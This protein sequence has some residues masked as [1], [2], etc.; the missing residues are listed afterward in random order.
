MVYFEYL[1]CFCFY[2]LCC[3]ILQMAV[4]MS[5]S[6]SIIFSLLMAYAEYRQ[7]AYLDLPGLSTVWATTKKKL[8][9][10]ASR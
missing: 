9:A 1:C 5:L 2:A 10:P 8:R 7:Q 4:M 3:R 6:P